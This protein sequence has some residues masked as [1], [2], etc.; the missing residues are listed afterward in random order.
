MKNIQLEESINCCGKLCDSSSSVITEIS[1]C[2]SQKV[3]RFA[4]VS[5]K[6][7]KIKYI[8]TVYHWVNKYIADAIPSRIRSMI[9]FLAEQIHKADS[10]ENN[11][12]FYHSTMYI[13]VV[14]L[15][16][17]KIDCENAYI[18]RYCVYFWIFYSF[19]LSYNNGME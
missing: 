6:Q 12:V 16:R 5:I 9:L 8:F 18:I 4:K 10:V 11:V 14:N 1:L 13:R 19:N 15:S 2:I 3:R 17:S 7:L